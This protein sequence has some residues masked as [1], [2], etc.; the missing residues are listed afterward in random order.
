MNGD[1]EPV[2]GADGSVLAPLLDGLDGFLSEEEVSAFIRSVDPDGIVVFGIQM[3]SGMDTMGLLVCAEGVVYGLANEQRGNGWRCLRREGLSGEIRQVFSHATKFYYTDVDARAVGAVGQSLVEHLRPM[4]P[5]D[6]GAGRGKTPPF[7][8]VVGADMQ[9]GCVSSGTPQDMKRMSDGF[10]SP[11]VVCSNCLRPCGLADVG[12]TTEWA[13]IGEVLDAEVA[14]E[15]ASEYTV[16]D[17]HELQTFYIQP[18][19]TGRDATPEAFGKVNRATILL[20]ALAQWECE[21]ESPHPSFSPEHDHSIVVVAP[22]DG[23][24]LHLPGYL[25]WRESSGKPTL[26]DFYVSPE[27][28]NRGIGT[29]MVRSWW[30]R[31]SETDTCWTVGLNAVG[32][33]T[34]NQAGVGEVERARAM[35]GRRWSA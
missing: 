25:C 28:R 8:R 22:D 32:L 26:T 6:P 3:V 35:T 11:I 13:P 9:C 19:Q 27:W 5:F 14:L 16:Y 18:E 10:A 4:L 7:E 1:V 29:Q 31:V 21:S 33:E 2:D 12:E 24:E 23:D 34:L 17:P 20:N 30:D 15:S